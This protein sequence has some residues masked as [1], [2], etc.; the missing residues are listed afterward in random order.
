MDTGDDAG[1]DAAPLFHDSDDE[2]VGHVVRNRR[3]REAHQQRPTKLEN[4]RETN[5][6]KKA[7][8]TKAQKEA[9]AAAAN[10]AL[11]DL[12]ATTL[13][14]DL[15]KG[16]KPATDARGFRVGRTQQSRFR[17]EGKGYGLDHIGS[18]VLPK[19]ID[20]GTSFH[21]DH[22]AHQNLL[23]KAYEKDEAERE[24][25]RRLHARFNPKLPETDPS[26]AAAS[27]ASAGGVEDDSWMDSTD[28]PIKGPTPNRQKFSTTQRN[29]LARAAEN[30][31]KEDAK[32]DEKELGKFVQR[33]PVLLAEWKKKDKLAAKEKA[34]IEH[35][36]ETQPDRKPRLGRYVEEEQF[37]DVALTEEL[38]EDG[39]L[40][41][42]K[43]TTHLLEDQF[44]R[45]QTRHLIETR[46]RV[47]P[48][49]VMKGRSY[50][51]FKDYT[52]EEQ[53]ADEAAEAAAAAAMKGQ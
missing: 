16:I 30:R 53:K 13:E 42:L 40:R 12:W 52:R 25:Q 41:M 19:Q 36:K 11:F 45:F 35:L 8:E 20:E 1:D 22:G 49:K 48:T 50:D 46:K 27:A 6:L 29:R 38:P 24:E 5:R 32:R 47:K 37:P 26:T 9:S 14:E 44:S 39:S 23:R 7:T 51:R 4:Q 10:P 17:H 43:P 2:V 21:P 28:E 31:A 33:I 15:Q 34:R 3:Q 18:S